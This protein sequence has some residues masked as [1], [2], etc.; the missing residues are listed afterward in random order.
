MLNGE[1]SAKLEEWNV[2]GLPVRYVLK[3]PRALAELVADP[4][5]TWELMRGTY[6]GDREQR[7]PPFPYEPDLNWERRLHA[8]IGA[9][10]PCEY[11]EDLWR[12][13]AQVMSELE[14]RGVRAGPESFIYWND[15]DAALV[16][17]I[18]CLIRH[19]NLKY[20]VETG[21][22]H[23][24]TSRF[25]LEALRRNGGGHLWSIDVPPVE[26]VWRVQVGM[27]VP[28]TLRSQWT[29]I[30]GTSRLRLPELLRKLGEVDLFVHDSLHS[31]RNVRFE[32]D[33]AW[34]ALKT[35]SAVVVDD[36][37]LNWGFRSF[38]QT[39][40]RYQS[41][42]CEAEPRRPDF[43]RC[44]DKGIFGIVLKIEGGSS[45]DF[46]SPQYHTRPS[47]ERTAVALP[48][49]SRVTTPA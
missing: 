44:N 11:A 35:G 48:G 47:F 12:L 43:R 6:L 4:S 41:L 34:S 42:V 19:L 46:A 29:Y 14:E 26:S 13:W 23:G 40:S 25:V 27:A 32:L 28:A 38:T 45:S 37:D 16:R 18:W 3:H 36:I 31:E 1:R 7:I 30:K 10:W 17:S 33:H 24:V 2:L 21:V 20:I 49:T 22:A 15:G 9:Q 8:L 39:V 5:D